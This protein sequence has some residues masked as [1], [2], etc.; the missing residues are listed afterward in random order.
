MKRILL[1]CLIGG[2]LIVAGCA[3]TTHGQ[4][5]AQSQL[6]CAGGTLAGAAIGAA[7]GNRFGGG[8]GQDIATAA[9]G[10]V[11]AVAGSRAAC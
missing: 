6:R 8:R 1:T 2:S 5:Q 4:A 9:G 7:A 10:G 11:G 3:P